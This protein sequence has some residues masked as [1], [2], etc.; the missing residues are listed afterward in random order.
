MPQ[1][2]AITPQKRKKRVNIFLDGQF[3]FGVD[4]ETLAKTDL[5]VGQVLSEE[6]IEEIVKEAELTQVLAR[7]LKFLSFR[8]RSEKEV[9]DW[10]LRKEVGFK[11]Q[12]LIRRKLK[13]QKLLDDKEFS[14]WWLEQRILFRPQGSRLLR[15]ELKRKGISEG[16]IEEV[17]QEVKD[18]FS[19]KKLAGKAALKKLRSLKNLSQEKTKEKLTSFLLRRGFSWEEVREVVEDL[20]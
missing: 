12:A 15:F 20:I 3:S 10:F 17:F 7:V 18:S 14:R 5:R 16:T 4:L 2:T 13:K 1:I 8:P 19:E 11:T 6:K 9:T